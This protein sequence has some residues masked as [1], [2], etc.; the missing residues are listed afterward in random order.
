MTFFLEGFAGTGTLN[1]KSADIGFGSETWVNDAAPNELELSG[2][3]A[4]SVDNTNLESV[5]AAQYGDGV[6]DYSGPLSPVIVFS[7]RTGPSVDG[8]VLNC[9][10]LSVDVRVGGHPFAL[11]V[12]YGQSAGSLW[13]IDFQGTQTTFTAAPNTTYSGSLSLADGSQSAVFDGQTINTSEAY[14]SPAL[15]LNSIRVVVGSTHKLDSIAV[16]LA[17]GLSGTYPAATAAFRSGQR[18]SI[19]SPTPTLFTRSGSGLTASSPTPTFL[20]TQTLPGSSISMNSPTPTLVFYGGAR[21]AVT[22]PTPMFQGTLNEGIRNEI[23]GMVA[24]PTMS[25]RSGNQLSGKFPVA[26]LKINGTTTILMHLQGV[27]PVATIQFIDTKTE[28]V[29]LTGVVSAAK[30]AAR[31]GGSIAGSYPTAT[32]E[33]S[34]TSGS[35]MTLTGTVPVGDLI[36]TGVAQAH[37]RIE[38]TVP[39]AQAGPYGRI[40]GTLAAAQISFVGTAVITV[41][42]EAYATNLLHGE[43]P[44]QVTRYTNFP[45]TH[46]LRYQGDYFGVSPNGLFL[47]G[48]VT[49]YATPKPTPIRWDFETHVTD[50]DSP[51]KKTIVAAYFGGR[52]G[53]SETVRLVA[54][55]KPAKTYQYTTPRGETAQNHRQKF[56][57]GIKERYFAVG[58]TGTG[59]LE[60]DNIEFDVA[61]MTRRI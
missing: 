38:G 58:A 39:V 29:S 34:A 31:A 22:S 14:D 7:F 2:G 21:V 11:A 15:G 9:L 13:T 23:A 20:A 36:F 44:A 10:G 26:A 28:S 19:Q 8:G 17:G 56:G 35:V 57:R 53:K 46:I 54:G 47:L 60:L 3:Y 48:G 45:F 42:Y 52:L 4:V 40:T 6:T 59:E 24:A 37:G 43:E 50:L 16:D 33:F 27:V 51:L 55:E 25:F 41:T 30:F 1:G 49:D 5:G 61:T 12:L 32:A 18:L